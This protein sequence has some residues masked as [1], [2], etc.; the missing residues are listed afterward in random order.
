[1]GAIL[2][3]RLTSGYRTTIPKAVADAL[4]LSPGDPVAFDIRE[5]GTVTM[6]S[7]ARLDIEFARAI[8]PL[9]SEWMSQEDEEAYSTL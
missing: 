7:E 1:M 8:E 2:M 9:L 6:R 5:N 4:G 3:S